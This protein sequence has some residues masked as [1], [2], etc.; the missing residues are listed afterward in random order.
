MQ[1]ILCCRLGELWVF[2]W[3]FCPFVKLHWTIVALKTKRKC[4][5]PR[6]NTTEG[7]TLS[8]GWCLTLTKRSVSA[9][10]VYLFSAAAAG[11]RNSVFGSSAVAAWLTDLLASAATTIP[12]GHT[13]THTV[14]IY[15]CLHCPSVCSSAMPS[16][17]RSH[18]VMWL[19]AGCV[20][21]VTRWLWWAHQKKTSLC[22]S[23]THIL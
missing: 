16:L 2:L 19:L 4:V 3:V 17:P 12:W 5:Q 22:L 21:M 10:C 1:T 9:W 8:T 11:D 23:H 14:C 7:E 13:H 6:S 20:T 15:L 18:H